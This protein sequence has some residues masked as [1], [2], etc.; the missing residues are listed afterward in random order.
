MV[1]VA[2]LTCAHLLEHD[3]HD[4]RVSQV[5]YEESLLLDYFR[6]QGVVAERVDW[7]DRSVDW[8]RVGCALF[9]STWNYLEN[10]SQFD[11]WLDHAR[12]KTRLSNSSDVVRWN[13]DKRYLEELERA[14]A[15]VVPSAFYDR[16]SATGVDDIFARL[17]CDEIVLKPRA[18]AG[19]LDTYR[20]TRSDAAAFDEKLRDLLSRKPMM[21]QPFQA[22]ILKDGELSLIVIA[23]QFTHAV[24]KVARDGE[25][26]IQDDHGGY[27]VPHA[28]SAE[29]KAFAEAVVRACPFP[30][31]YARVDVV[32]DALGA[33]ALME[34]ELFEPELFF[35]FDRTAAEAL[36]QSV[37]A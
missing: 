18:S 16:G 22:S 32:Y 33:L 10:M 15:A 17:G 35:R 34:V 3:P 25:F 24:R 2:L 21:A 27:A 31:Q 26:R 13:L 6:R 8:S 29:E 12:G 30:L 28:A 7:A 14:G 37:I 5:F 4:F 9:R 19:G 36:A 20:L 11:A 1:D 23:G